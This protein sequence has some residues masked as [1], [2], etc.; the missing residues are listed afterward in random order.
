MGAVVNGMAAHGGVIPYGATFLVFSDY[1]RPAIRLSALARHPA[2]WVF[3]HDSVALGEDGPTHQPVEQLTSLRLIPNLVVIRPADANETAQAWKTAIERRQ[4]PTALILTRQTVP[5]LDR[6]ILSPADGLAKGAYIL[7]DIG[8]GH[9]DIILMASGSEVALIVEAGLRIAAEGRNVRLVSFPS[10]ELFASQSTEYR[11]RVLPPG[12][13]ARLVVEAGAALGWERWVGSQ[14]SILGLDHF[15]A[16][17][18][19]KVIMEALGFSADQVVEAAMEMIATEP[20]LA[21]RALGNEDGGKE[22]QN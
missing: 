16:S 20:C 6:T 12:V 18:P 17:A 7:A 11:E 8:D 3:T 15:G 5:T 22:N 1:M 14:G 19:G 13:T 9:P 4:G 2:V 21:S 10:W